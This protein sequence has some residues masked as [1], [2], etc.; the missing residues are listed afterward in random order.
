M[1]SVRLH[2]DRKPGFFVPPWALPALAARWLGLGLRVRAGSTD[3]SLW[4]HYSAGARVYCGNSFPDG[5]RKNDRRA[6]F[7]CRIVNR[8]PLLLYAVWS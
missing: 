7:A 8:L 3:T 5:M 2:G 4:T 6:L 1:S